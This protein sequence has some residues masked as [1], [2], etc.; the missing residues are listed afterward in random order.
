[1]CVCASITI[2]SPLFWRWEVPIVNLNGIFVDRYGL[3]ITWLVV[4]E[5]LWLNEFI[6]LNWTKEDIIFEMNSL[7]CSR[8]S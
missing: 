8:K 3:A 4:V 6:M 1:M 2:Y 5:M 7:K